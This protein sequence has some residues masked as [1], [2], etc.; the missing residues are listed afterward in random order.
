MPQ[1]LGWLAVA[2]ECFRDERGLLPRGL[3]TSAF[4]LVV[5]LERLWHLDAMEDVG[6]ALLTG[7]GRCPSRHASGGWRRHLPWYEVDAFCRRTSPWHHL[8]GDVALLSYDEH[9]IPRGTAKFHIP[10]G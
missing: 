5:G 3:L 7:G 9:T 2:R 1:A 6:F 8:R 10:K 4:A